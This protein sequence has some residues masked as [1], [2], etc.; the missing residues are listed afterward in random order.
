M[1]KPLYTS[2]T[3]TRKM[4]GGPGSGK[5]TALL[6]I[7]EQELERGTAPEQI[8]F[9]AFTRAA[10]I[11]ARTR[12]EKRFNLKRKQLPWFRT[13]H[14]LAYDGVGANPSQMMQRDN[15]VELGELLHVNLTR[16]AFAADG[17]ATGG[18]REGERL[19]YLYGLAQARQAPLLELWHEAGAGLPW[20]SLEQFAETLKEYKDH[21]GLFDF[22]DLLHEFAIMGERLPVKAVL[23]DEAQDLTRAQWAVVGTAFPL[24][25]RFYVAG[26]DDQALYEWAGADTEVFLD[27]PGPVQ[28]LPVSYR[29]P[30]SV[31]ELAARVIAQVSR[32]QEKDWKSTERVGT[33][34]TVAD[35][36]SVDL[37]APGSWLLLAR[38][39]YLL[40]DLAEVC[41]QQGVPYLLQGKAMTDPGDV[42]AILSWGRL[43]KGHT[44]PKAFVPTLFERLRM[45]EPENVG[46]TFNGAGLDLTAPWYEVLLNI[47][48]SKREFYRACLRSGESLTETPRVR[49]S[50][51]HG[52][53][54]Q[55]ADHVLLRSDMAPRTYAGYQINPDIE[56]RT[57]YVGM[58]RAR[59][60]LH[61]MLPT[62]ERAYEFPR[63][64]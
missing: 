19:R 26:D 30:K 56:H 7:V 40:E 57:F 43:I 37:T 44:I 61:L 23:I 50:T 36:S 58:T 59:K 2:P 55:E 54:G 33:V 11:E 31:F 47:P 28:V 42:E 48:M 39:R 27:L 63:L 32:R 6:D 20:K 52:A 53:K 17:P 29:L 18:L 64:D 4:F 15:W 46:P 49:I 38:N 45:P 22:D 60:N 10:S 34:A 5:T 1:S 21:L 41:V 16:T 13:L 9:V 14:S 51:I 24:G 62:S 8:A 35:P 3:K 12:A 25:A